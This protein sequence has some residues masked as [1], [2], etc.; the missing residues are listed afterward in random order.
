MGVI[1]ALKELSSDIPV[2][3]ASGTKGNTVELQKTGFRLKSLEKPYS[4][5][6]LLMAVASGLQR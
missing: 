4:L 2:I 5:D 1:R 3:I 6:Q